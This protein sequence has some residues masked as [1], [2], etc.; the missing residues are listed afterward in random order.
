MSSLGKEN[1][2]AIEKW[3]K[4][5]GWLLIGTGERGKDTLGGFDSSFMEVSCKRVSKV[6]EENDASKEMQ[7]LGSYSGFTGIDFSQM[8]VA[9]LQRNNINASKSE[10]YPGW[11]YACG[12]GC[13]G[14]CAISFG[15]KQMQKASPDLCYGI[16]DQVAG[17]SMSYS[18]YVNDEEWGWS[19]ENAFG[20]IDHLNTALDF[21]WLKVLI[22]VY[23]IVVG[24]CFIFFFAR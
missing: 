20:V 2:K 19:G 6:G 15:E 18:Q 12:D 4:N 10:A 11:V 22:V 21:S 17:Y 24:P 1:I 14:V 23:V 13:H 8:P 9:K 3:V 7:Q 5:G 16:Y